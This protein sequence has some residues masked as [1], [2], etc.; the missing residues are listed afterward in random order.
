VIN[1]QV[2]TQKFSAL[3]NTVAHR[4]REETRDWLVANR[5]ELIFAVDDAQENLDAVWKSVQDGAAQPVAFDIALMHW[6]IAHN[7]ALEA[8]EKR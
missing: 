5:P 7:A 2:L 3:K 8:W 4:W 1:A 6:G